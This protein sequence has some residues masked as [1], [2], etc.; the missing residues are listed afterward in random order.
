MILTLVT[1]SLH[2]CGK[3]VTKPVKTAA[4]SKAKVLRA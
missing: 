4:D 1:F 3:H 2:L